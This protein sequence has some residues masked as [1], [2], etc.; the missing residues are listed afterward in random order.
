MLVLPCAGNIYMG[1]WPRNLQ[2]STD[3]QNLFHDWKLDDAVVFKSLIEK[4]N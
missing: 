4:K 2:S 3:L 1:I